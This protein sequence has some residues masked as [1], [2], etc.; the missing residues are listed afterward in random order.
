MARRRKSRIGLPKARKLSPIELKR[1]KYMS[2]AN[3]GPINAPRFGFTT[4]KLGKLD[5][6][7]FYAKFAAKKFLDLMI[8]DDEVEW[9]SD[10]EL[11]TDNDLQIT[12]EDLRKI[13][14]YKIKYNEE[15]YHSFDEEAL[16]RIAIMRSDDPAKP[17]VAGETHSKR[18]RVSRKGMTLM[19]TI[20]EEV[21]MTPRVA[22]GILRGVMKKPEQGWA[23]R[24]EAEVN[25]IRAILLGKPNQRTLDFSKADDNEMDEGFDPRPLV[26]RTRRPQD[27]TTT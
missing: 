2:M 23:W 24:T 8:E 10:K 18:R 27:P 20:A 26:S 17:F 3:S 7:V 14:N 25:R 21:G 11:H 1:E 22:R 9:V 5:A 12:G 6:C 19:K 16:R 4:R 15:R 13:F